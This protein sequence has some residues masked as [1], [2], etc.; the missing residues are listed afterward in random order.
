MCVLAIF[1][2]HWECDSQVDVWDWCRVS[3][4]LRQRRQQA[5]YVHVPSSINFSFLYM[6]SFAFNWQAVCSINDPIGCFVLFSLV[7]SKATFQRPKNSVGQEEV[8]RLLAGAICKEGTWNAAYCCVW[9][10]RVW[11]RQHSKSLHT[12]ILMLFLL[13]GYKN[14]LRSHLPKCSTF[15]SP[16]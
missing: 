15:V 10:G 6:S 4:W 13:N 12:G 7:Q 3:P 9:H 8:C 11:H 2:S 16:E 5:L 14:V 1:R